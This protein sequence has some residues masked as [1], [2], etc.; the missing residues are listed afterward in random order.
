MKQVA[1]L[2]YQGIFKRSPTILLF[3]MVGAVFVEEGIDYTSTYIFNRINQGVS[4]ISLS[5]GT[6]M[7]RFS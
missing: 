6:C 7:C 3:A 2:L 1:R 4:I 5:C